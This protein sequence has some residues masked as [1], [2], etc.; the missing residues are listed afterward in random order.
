[1]VHGKSPK[2]GCQTGQKRVANG[3]SVL[4]SDLAWGGEERDVPALCA[5]V[6]A[7]RLGGH[8]LPSFGRGSPAIFI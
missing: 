3:E 4:L 5:E 7:Q 1:M 2:S 8:G 6:V